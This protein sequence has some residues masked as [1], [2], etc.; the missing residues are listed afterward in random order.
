MPYAV[1]H[2]WSDQAYQHVS[3]VGVEVLICEP[4]FASTASL[5]FDAAQFALRLAATAAFHSHTI[6]SSLVR[7]YSSIVGHAVDTG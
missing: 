5:E 6:S 4:T 1:C 7:C 2:S 3:E